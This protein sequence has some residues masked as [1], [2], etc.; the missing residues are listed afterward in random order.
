MLAD[1][2]AVMHQGRVEQIATADELRQAPATDYVRELLA[3]A[4]VMRA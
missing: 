2:V 1:R 4:R 3:R